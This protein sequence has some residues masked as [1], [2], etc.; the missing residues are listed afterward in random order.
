M[1]CLHR[2]F[3]VPRKL[4]HVPCAHRYSQHPLSNVQQISNRE[5]QP[6]PHPM[7][8]VKPVEECSSGEPFHRHTS[9][10]SCSACIRSSPVCVC[11]CECE[12]KE[13]EKPW[14]ASKASKARSLRA[15]LASSCSQVTAMQ[16]AN[17]CGHA[18]HAN[19]NALK[20][21]RSNQAVNQSAGRYTQLGA[22][23]SQAAARLKWGGH[24]KQTTTKN[25]QARMPVPIH[26][27]RLQAQTDNPTLV[28]VICQAKRGV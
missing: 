25:T 3:R 28:R 16:N 17:V 1:L 10:T 11:V 8:Q 15:L 5:S 23:R 9:C 27:K 19:D 21:I 4:S 2:I 13:M 24:K 20:L 7:H 18:T 22:L 14:N 12:T 6:A 26:A